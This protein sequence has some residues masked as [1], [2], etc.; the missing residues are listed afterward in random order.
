MAFGQGVAELPMGRRAP[1]VEEAGG[2]EQIG[3]GA[4]RCRAARAARGARD[5]VDDRGIARRSPGALAAGHDQRVVQGHRVRQRSSAEAQAVG[6]LD[7][8]ILR[9]RHHLDVVRAGDVAVG[10]EEHLDRS[11]HVE[12]LRAVGGQDEDA[13]DRWHG[14][15][16]AKH[17]PLR[18]GQMPHESRHRRHADP[19]RAL[20][21]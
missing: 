2:G 21:G 10:V 13:A 1:P 11:E 14:D 19:T 8:A 4:D 18:S 9:G 6:Q 16:P 17:G 15:D 12:R 7:L 3:A 20:N 5:P